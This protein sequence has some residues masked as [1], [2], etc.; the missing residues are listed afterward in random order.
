ML[1][2][3]QKEIIIRKYSDSY[4]YSMLNF[5][6]LIN[7]KPLVEIRESIRIEL[8]SGLHI[9][10]KIGEAEKSEKLVGIRPT[11]NELFGGF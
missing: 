5:E 7:D 10:K 6:M 8:L 3:G 11:S 4:Y 1:R 9:G 2:K